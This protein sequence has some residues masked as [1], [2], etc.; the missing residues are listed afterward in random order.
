MGSNNH[1]NNEDREVEDVLDDILTRFFAGS[2]YFSTLEI[3]I[4]AKEL[5]NTINEHRTPANALLRLL[6]GAVIRFMGRPR[7]QNEVKILLKSLDRDDNAPSS[8]LMDSLNTAYREWVKE[9][10]STNDLWL[11]HFAKDRTSTLVNPSQNNQR[12]I[13][14]PTARTSVPDGFSKLPDSEIREIM[15]R[16]EADEK[17]KHP[18][19]FNTKPGPSK[20]RV[21]PPY[22]PVAFATDD[23]GHRYLSDRVLGAILPTWEEILSSEKKRSFN[24]YKVNWVNLAK[25]FEK[26]SAH[27]GEK[28]DKLGVGWPAPYVGHRTDFGD[29]NRPSQVW[30]KVKPAREASASEV[31]NADSNSEIGG[32]YQDQSNLSS[33][34][35]SPAPSQI[36]NPFVSQNG[37]LSDTGEGSSRQSGTSNISNS[38]IQVLDGLNKLNQRMDLMERVQRG[39]QNLRVRDREDP[40]RGVSPTASRASSRWAPSEEPRSSPGFS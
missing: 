21:R 23:E 8:E 7:A 15:V 30:Y 11:V 26:W 40:I 29:P 14:L 25:E 4:A 9:A 32:S 12:N 22:W 5:N 3:Q 19:I 10:K 35:Q 34:A 18:E 33:R 39:L 36:S 1:L 24:G 38:L 20:G 6:M 17:M 16:N 28:L 2:E 31:S 37:R 13:A 27:E